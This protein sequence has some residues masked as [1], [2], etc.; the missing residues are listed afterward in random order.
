MATRD[1]NESRLLDAREIVDFLQLSFM[2]GRQGQTGAPHVATS[3]LLVIAHWAGEVIERW[4]L[5]RSVLEGEL[6]LELAGNE[7]RGRLPTVAEA[8]T[9]RESGLCP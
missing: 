2:I 5:I 1:D 9:L 3:E 6:V 7:P 4:L 8:A